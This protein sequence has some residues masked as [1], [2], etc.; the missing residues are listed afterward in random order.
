MRKKEKMEQV[1]TYRE[2]CDRLSITAQLVGV[3]MFQ[4]STVL[5]VLFRSKKEET[6]D[7]LL[8]SKK[9]LKG[10]SLV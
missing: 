8:S 3:D 4:M 9:K 6:L 2:A 1:I 10:I 5:A 7:D